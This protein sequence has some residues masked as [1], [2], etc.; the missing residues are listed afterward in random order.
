MYEAIGKLIS[1]QEAHGLF[2]RVKRIDLITVDH[3]QVE[4]DA[5][6]SCLFAQDTQILRQ[7][8]KVGTA[9]R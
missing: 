3:F 6:L 7:P 8:V 2:C 9:P 1:I 4:S 5:P